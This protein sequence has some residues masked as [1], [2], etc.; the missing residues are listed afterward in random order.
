VLTMLAHI[1]W[2][3]KHPRR[4]RDGRFPLPRRRWA[5]RTR[6]PTQENDV[7]LT[8]SDDDFCG[9]GLPTAARDSA[10]ESQPAHTNLATADRPPGRS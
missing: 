2:H 7:G 4:F 5:L 1:V 6:P 3:R 9:P 8:E 10:A